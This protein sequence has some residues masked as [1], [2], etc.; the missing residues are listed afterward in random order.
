M[1]PPHPPV[2]RTV[3]RRLSHNSHVLLTRISTTNLGET[4]RAY[5]RHFRS[6]NYGTLLRDG[7]NL[8]GFLPSLLPSRGVNSNGEANLNSPFLA[9]GV[10]Y[11]SRASVKYICIYIYI[12]YASMRRWTLERK[13]ERE[14]DSRGRRARPLATR[15]GCQLRAP[16]ETLTATAVPPSRPQCR[17]VTRCR[18]DCDWPGC[19]ARA[20]ARVHVSLHARTH[21]HARYVGSFTRTHVARE[22]V[23]KEG[24]EAER[25]ASLRLVYTRGLCGRA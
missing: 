8:P 20:R 19:L 4:R 21:T 25:E 6:E 1:T 24:G 14:R 23:G 2:R 17:L 15:S 9:A 11:T 16:R 13:Y 3:P 22:A 12:I 18:E 10:A 5:H 7:D